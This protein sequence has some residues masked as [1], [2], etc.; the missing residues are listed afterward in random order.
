MHSAVR[1]SGI[2]ADEAAQHHRQPCN[3]DPDFNT[4]AVLIT[5]EVRG[6]TAK[7]YDDMLAV[8]APILKQAPGLVLHSAHATEDGWRV[9][10]VWETKSQSDRFFAEVVAPHLT[11]GVQPK[12]SVVVLHS[13]ILPAAR[14]ARSAA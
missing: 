7:G 14:T 4:M 6:Q 12:R 10:E 8:L 3:F 5:A 2:D 13:A 11:P 1:R 9:I